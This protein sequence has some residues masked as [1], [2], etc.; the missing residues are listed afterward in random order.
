LRAV[1]NQ[2]S[3][4]IPSLRDQHAKLKAQLAAERAAVEAV[5]DCDPEAMEELKAGIAEQK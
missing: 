2:F 4:P 5:K 1:G 3:D